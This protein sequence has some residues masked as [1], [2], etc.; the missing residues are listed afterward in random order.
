MAL[1]PEELHKYSH[2]RLTAMS[3]L[4]VEIIEN[5]VPDYPLPA[6]FVQSLEDLRWDIDREIDAGLNDMEVFETQVMARA[7]KEKSH[8]H[9]QDENCRSRYRLG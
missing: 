9:Y 7:S 1:L 3:D 5:L 4:L 6:K 2:I 8:V